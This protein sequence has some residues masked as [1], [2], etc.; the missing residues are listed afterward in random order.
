LSARM[1]G[2]HGPAASAPRLAVSRTAATPRTRWPRGL[3]RRTCGPCFPSLCIHIPTAQ[4]STKANRPFPSVGHAHRRLLASELLRLLDGIHALRFLTAAI[5]VAR[6][7]QRSVGRSQVLRFR[8]PGAFRLLRR[9]R[10]TAHLALDVL[11][12][13]CWRDYRTLV[14][15]YALS[16]VHRT[17][18]K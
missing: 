3:R 17:R 11:R 13:D 4:S 10:S 15:L 9:G 5:E 16:S 8:P 1:A 7:L 14:P 2:S 6:L 18:R 12:R